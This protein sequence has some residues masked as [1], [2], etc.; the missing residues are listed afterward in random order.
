M[1]D[2]TALRQVPLF[3]HMSDDDLA[4]VQ[5]LMTP[6][7]FAPGEVIIREGE[8]GDDFFIVVAGRAKIAVRAGDGNEL[9]VGEAGPGGFFGELS[10]LT[11]EP[12]SARVQA[13]EAVQT[14]TLH[15]DAFLEFLT[16]HPQAAIAV[17]MELGHRLHRTDSLLKQ[18]VSRNVNEVDDERLT[19]GLRLA[20]KVAGVAGSIPFLVLHTFLFCFWILLNQ[21]W[22]PGDKFDPS[23]HDGLALIVGLEAALL[24][25]FVL[26][27]QNQEVAKDRLA[28][29]IDHQINTKAEVEIGLLLQRVDDLETIVRHHAEEQKQLLTR[30][31]EKSAL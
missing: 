30:L 10:M 9:V 26:I 15:R 28:A 11:G 5:R 3:A 14:M 16:R 27:S 7:S 1:T 17:L 13:V 18:A 23:P 21:P 24:S 20:N 22:F 2:Q 6:L 31:A 19:W 8:P 29:E 12:R 4:D 25:I